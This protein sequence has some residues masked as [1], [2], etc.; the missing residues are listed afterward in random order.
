[1]YGL[2]GTFTDDVHACGFCHRDH[3]DRSMV[4]TEI[5]HL[6]RSAATLE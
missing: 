1:M 2:D 5:G 3:S 6:D 4:I